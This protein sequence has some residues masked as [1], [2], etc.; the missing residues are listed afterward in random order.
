MR[1]LP[2][3]IVLAY[4]GPNEPDSASSN[5]ICTDGKTACLAAAATFMSKVADAGKADGVSVF[6]TS[7]GLN[8]PDPGDYGTTGDLS[9]FADYGNAHTYFQTG[10]GSRAPSEDG[11]F[12]RGSIYWLNKD[13][14]L[15]TPNKPIAITE[16]GYFV[17]G[18]ADAVTPHAQAVYTMEVIFDAFIEKNPY[19][20]HYALYEDASGDWGLFDDDHTP[21]ESATDL[22][23]LFTILA[24]HGASAADFAAGKLDFTFGAL[25]TGPN[26][27]MGGKSVL[28]QKKDGRFELVL[29]NEQNINAGEAA[30][31]DVTLTFNSATM[32]SIDVYD[33][34]V[35][36]ASQKHLSQVKSTTVSMPSHPI[37]LEI[38]HP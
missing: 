2:R 25:P 35:G 29:W 23:N 36:V 38:V 22:K 8:Y 5:G 4:E 34:T 32:T 15:T 21:R 33:P 16:F 14:A 20:F 28:L 26:V 17:S 9:Q 1:K 6:Q 37:V 10:H 31:V 3:K 27:G 13:A 24:D 11:I 19:Y 12:D 7:F 18:G 30:P